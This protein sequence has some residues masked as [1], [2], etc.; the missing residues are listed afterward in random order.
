M[1]GRTTNGPSDGEPSKV[2]LF[3]TIQQK[4][5]KRL[6]A[7]LFASYKPKRKL[8]AGFNGDSTADRE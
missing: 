6:H 1:S 5:L 2:S 8:P 7:R 3:S 4:T